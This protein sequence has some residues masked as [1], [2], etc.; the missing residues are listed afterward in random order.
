MIGYGF[1]VGFGNGLGLDPLKKAK[2]ENHRNTP[3]HN[4]HKSTK[5]SS[6]FMTLS[7]INLEIQTATYRN[8]PSCQFWR[9]ASVHNKEWHIYFALCIFLL[10]SF[11]CKQDDRYFW[12][13]FGD[14]RQLKKNIKPGNHSFILYF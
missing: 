9:Q 10:F 8:A 6:L 12:G 14:M 11:P 1:L 13:S 3:I 4:R 2:R 5:W 7:S